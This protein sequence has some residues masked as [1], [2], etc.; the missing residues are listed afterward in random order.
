MLLP[1]LAGAR[2]GQED[3]LRDNLRADRLGMIIYAGTT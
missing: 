3:F 2:A 1:V